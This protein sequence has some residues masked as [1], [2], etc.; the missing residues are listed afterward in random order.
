MIGPNPP[1]DFLQEIE[2]NKLSKIK[3]REVIRIIEENKY[4]QNSYPSKDKDA[5][6]IAKED[7]QDAQNLGVTCANVGKRLCSIIKYINPQKSRDTIKEYSITR[8][9]KRFIHLIHHMKNVEENSAN[10]KRLP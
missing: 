4:G 2:K 9:A 10:Q 7:I 1:S 3:V 8:F 6:I 5:L